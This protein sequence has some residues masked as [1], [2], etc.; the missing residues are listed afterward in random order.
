[1]RLALVN[2][3][4]S[5]EGSIYFGCRE[6]HLPLEYGYARAL[7]E[8]AGHEATIVDAQARDLSQDAVRDEVAALR[9]DAVVVTTAPSYLFWRCAPPELRVPQQTLHAL[10]GLP[11]L[12]FAVGPH[13]STTPRA[14]LRKL[15]VDAVVMGECEEVLVKLADLPRSRWG[16]IA[17]IAYVDGDE[18]RVQGGPHGADMARLPALRWDD[19]TVARHAH[20]HHRFDTAPVG[21]GAEVEASRGCPYNCTFCAKDNFRDRYRKRPLPVLLDELD[22]LIAQGVRYV[23]FIDEIFLPDRP[24]LEA[25]VDRPVSFGIQMR[26]DNWS[27]EM[28]DLLGTAGCVSIEAGV[29]SITKEGRSL[30]AK[31]CKLSTEQLSDLLIHA[32]KSVPFVQANLIQS[33]TDDPADVTAFRERLRQHGVWANEPVPMFPYPGSPDYTMRWGRPDDQAWERSVEHYLGQF[34]HFSDIQESRPLPLSELEV[35]A[36][37]HG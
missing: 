17:S 18:A 37:G 31:H 35:A 26:I 11:G 8:A 30:L 22:G 20:H 28:L 12:R 16:E 24:L 15:A 32:K 1:M 9:P 23:Y 34:D 4:W 25:L 3:P 21:P 36:P 19:A 5:F 10:R 29:E 2:P 6:P 27:R 14:T 33:Q 7:L 13:A